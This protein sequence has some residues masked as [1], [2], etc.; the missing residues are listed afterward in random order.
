MKT[1]SRSLLVS[2]LAALALAACGQPLDPTP[3]DR[4]PERVV[5][6]QKLMESFRLDDG[7]KVSPVL[8]APDGATRVGFMLHVAEHAEDV[9][10]QLAAR[11]VEPRGAWQPAEF[12]WAED[13]MR[14]GRI[15]LD[16]ISTAVEV[17]LP[18]EQAGLITHLTYDAIVPGDPARIETPDVD[19]QLDGVGTAQ[20][21]NAITISGVNNRAAWN[22]RATLCSSLNT[23]K[24]KISVHH[25]VTPTGSGNYPA[26][27]RG[28]QN[29][30]MDSNGWCDIGYHFM[31]T[32]DGQGWEAREAKY[33]G[34]H[35][36]GNNTNNLGV[37][38]IGCFQPGVDPCTQ[39]AF[40]PVNP[41]Q[42]MIDGGGDLIGKL[43][44]YYGINVNGNTVIGHRD[45]PGQST[46]CPGDN[47]HS[48]LPDLRDIANGATSTGTVQG[49]IWDLSITT[50]ASQSLDLGARLEGATIT[51]SDGQTTESREGDG[52]WSF[53]A[54]PGNYTLTVA[55]D[56]FAPASDTVTVTAG[57]AVWNSMGISPAVVPEPEP[58]PEP[59]PEPLTEGTLSLTV[60]DVNAGPTGVIQNATVDITG[61]IPVSTDADGVAE[62]TLPAGNIAIQVSAEGYEPASLNE[63]IVPGET[64]TVQVGLSPVTVTEPE[65]QPEPQPEPEA[66]PEP[67][68]EPEAQPEPQPEGE[69]EATFEP[70]P[71]VRI[72]TEDPDGQTPLAGGCSSS[73]VPAS[74]LPALSIGLMMVV[75]GRVRRRRR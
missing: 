31:V 30:H 45:N 35:V 50:D 63:L 37:S 47:L 74:G 41:P 1:P 42:A 4:V 64:T 5:S 18:L 52:F 13:N 51:L 25:T 32:S 23:T 33:L 70:E 34:A 66:Q 73:E 6:G 55:L 20:A 21:Q 54:E 60:F 17:R 15:E 39:S 7:M 2:T 44:S 28:I 16:V 49:V 65:P 26:A 43:A 75:A 38:F 53:D 9:V 8:A 72:Q 12:T 61:A 19:V 10:L 40:A 36:G 27:V 57:V 56:G 46:S 67:Q 29:Y 68:P 59:E 71:Q 58:Q 3:M 11:S 62:L 24:T 48:R 22:A 14:V 69:P